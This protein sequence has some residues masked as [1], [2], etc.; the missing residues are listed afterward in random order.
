VV[1][2][3]GEQRKMKNSCYR[4]A[5]AW[6]LRRGLDTRPPARLRLALT[7]CLKKIILPI[8]MKGEINQWARST[9]AAAETFHG[10]N[11]R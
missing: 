10:Y 9:R 6:E 7:K 3:S 1:E 2:I 5:K 8:M 11:D 4:F